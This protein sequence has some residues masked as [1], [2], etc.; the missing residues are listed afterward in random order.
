MLGASFVP[1]NMNGSKGVMEKQRERIKGGLSWL[2]PSLRKGEK[3]E[4]WSLLYSSSQ[5]SPPER[6]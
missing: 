4:N 3:M 6:D 5:Y 2:A 1:G